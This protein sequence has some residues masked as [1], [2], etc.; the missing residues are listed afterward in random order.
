VLEAMKMQNEIRASQPGAV[1]R[2]EVAA[3]QTVE[4]GFLM[5]S[6]RSVKD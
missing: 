3:D 6:I 1:E 4:A 5:L 2:L